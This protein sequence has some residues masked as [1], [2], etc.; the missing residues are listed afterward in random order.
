MAQQILVL[1]LFITLRVI[2]YK[3]GLD[4]GGEIYFDLLQN[5]QGKKINSSQTKIKPSELGAKQNE[6]NDATTK[7][8]TAAKNNSAT[9]LGASLSHFLLISKC[10]VGKV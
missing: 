2:Q 3:K 4:E 5:S 8:I 7:K 9:S 10:V 1:K 6:L